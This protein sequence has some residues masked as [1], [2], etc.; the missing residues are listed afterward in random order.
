MRSRAWTSS[1]ADRNIATGEPLP[2]NICCF[3]NAALN[4]GTAFLVPSWL[5]MV[6]E[7]GKCVLIMDGQRVQGIT[8]AFEREGEA[9]AF[10]FLSGP[11]EA[12]R[13]ARTARNL[14]L[15]L[16]D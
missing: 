8:F 7:A 1:R 4:I 13:K 11:I 3:L 15:E 10:A 9:Q 5:H 16:E 14:S 2:P 12:L 6:M